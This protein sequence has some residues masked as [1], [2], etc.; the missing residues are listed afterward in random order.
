MTKEV[1][2]I[3]Q[4]SHVGASKTTGKAVRWIVS[5]KEAYNGGTSIVIQEFTLKGPV[6]PVPPIPTPIPPPPPASPSDDPSHSAAEKSHPRQAGWGSKSVLVPLFDTRIALDQCHDSIVELVFKPCRPD[7]QVGL[8]LGVLGTEAGTSVA[9]QVTDA[10]FWNLLHPEIKVQKQAVKTRSRRGPSSSGFDDD[11]TQDLQQ[12]QQQQED[13]IQGLT[14][15]SFASERNSSNSPRGKN[16]GRLAVVTLDSVEVP[17]SIG[18][19]FVLERSLQ[20]E[21]KEGELYSLEDLTGGW[22]RLRLHLGRVF[23]FPPQPTGTH[24]GGGKATVVSQL[25]VTLDYESHPSSPCAPRQE[26]H[27]SKINNQD[28]SDDEDESYPLAILGSLS[29]VPATSAHMRGSHILGLKTDGNQVR[30]V[31]RSHQQRTEDGSASIA[32]SDTRADLSLHHHDKK[33][34]RN[35]DHQHQHQHPLNPHHSHSQQ[36]DDGHERCWQLRV[37]TTVSWNLG[38]PLLAG[39]GSIQPNKDVLSS[40]S[41]TSQGAVVSPVEYSH[42]CVYLMVV[43]ATD[44]QQAAITESSIVQ[45]EKEGEVQ[46]VGTAFGSRFRIANFEVFLDHVILSE[47][48]RAHV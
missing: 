36:G 16:S 29:V 27:D 1:F 20:P 6:L 38:F 44:R 28:G 43:H 3:D 14:A 40:L 42:F 30:I 34:K 41:E 11:V 33:S 9:R 18:T 48:G 45:E 26:D 22:R 7:V 25:G 8:H 23:A 32:L 37:S 13:R 47:I 10:E 19:G 21:G 24:A 39:Q 35:D 46:F 17:E 12:Q 15:S 2:L 5:P 4:E 31:K